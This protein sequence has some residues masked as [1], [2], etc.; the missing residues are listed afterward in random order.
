MGDFGIKG[1]E[2]GM[3]KQCNLLQMGPSRRVRRLTLL[4][5]EVSELSA[6]EPSSA[7]LCLQPFVLSGMF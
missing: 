2:R 5:E 7:S 1:V 4:F 3:V 6:A